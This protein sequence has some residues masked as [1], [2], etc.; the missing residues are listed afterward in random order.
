MR[1]SPAF[2]PLRVL[3]AVFALLTIWQSPARSQETTTTA[4]SGPPRRL[5]MGQALS[6]SDLPLTLKLRD[7][8]GD[9]RRVSVNGQLDLGGYTQILSVAMSSVFGQT[10][11]AVYY[12]RGDTV[13]IGSETYIVAYRP[14]LKTVDIGGLIMEAAKAGPKMDPATIQ[15]TLMDRLTPEKLTEETNLALT[16]L[17][18]RTSGTLADIRPFDL[19][20]EIAEAP[21]GIL[22]AVLA[23]AGQEEIKDPSLGNLK[24]LGDALTAYAADHDETYPTLTDAASI[25]TALDPYVTDKAAFAHPASKEAYLPNPVLSGK[26][27]GSLE[28]YGEWMIAFYEANPAADG[29]RGVVTLDGTVKRV[30]E[31]EW[32]QLKKASKIP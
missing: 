1:P 16:L 23:A 28:Q 27:T 21:K 8:N 26:R 13:T 24:K 4:P 7:L 5:E 2:S 10:G 17:N 18:L 19:Q 3:P 32:P 6:G 9:W 15:K 12:T 11:S 25:Q 31:S 29:T 14:P 22:E 30:Q 20:R